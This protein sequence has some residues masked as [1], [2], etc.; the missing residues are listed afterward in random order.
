MQPDNQDYYGNNIIIQPQN[1]QNR[2]AYAD[3]RALK[4]KNDIPAFF[5]AYVGLPLG[6]VGQGGH[7]AFF[8]LNLF[9]LQKLPAIILK[10][11]FAQGVPL[12]LRA[13]QFL[14]NG[15]R[16]REIDIFLQNPKLARL[17]ALRL[18]WLVSG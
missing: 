15:K 4:A 5:R 16:R 3:F 14:P 18:A 10:P 12:R 8:E 6:L 13:F 2:A 1:T 9:P 11:G 17:Q 7:T